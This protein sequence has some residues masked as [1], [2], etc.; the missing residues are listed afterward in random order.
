[1]KSISVTPEKAA[2]IVK[3][4][5]TTMEAL[6]SAHSQFAKL[7]SE[8]ATDINNTLTSFEGSVRHYL[9]LSNE[10]SQGL[11]EVGRH[12]A[13]LS[14]SEYTTAIKNGER[15][16]SIVRELDDLQKAGA[17]SLIKLP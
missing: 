7:V 15:I 2:A 12:I 9:V 14:S 17:M 10:L 8:S 1:M 6:R 13:R 11:T 4:V 16:L 5:E 3:D